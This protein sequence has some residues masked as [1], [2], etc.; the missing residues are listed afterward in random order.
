MDPHDKIF[1]FGTLREVRQKVVSELLFFGISQ[2][3]NFE[4]L[5]GQVDIIASAFNN[6][7]NRQNNL[8]LLLIKANVY[9]PLI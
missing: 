2:K 5:V 9:K 7:N 1:M 8:N 6:V 4:Q 3:E